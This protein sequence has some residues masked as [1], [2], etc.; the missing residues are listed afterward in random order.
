MCSVTEQ[1]SVTFVLS[2]TAGSGSAESWCA[3]VPGRFQFHHSFG[4]D[5]PVPLHTA[6]VVVC[7]LCSGSSVHDDYR[8]FFHFAAVY[9]KEIRE[10]VRGMTQGLGRKET[11]VSWLCLRG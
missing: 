7:V 1:L 3:L 10:I 2:V 8:W 6:S 5:A 11:V 9:L 4:I